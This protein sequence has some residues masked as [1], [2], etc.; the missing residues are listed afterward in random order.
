MFIEAF[1]RPRYD[2][3]KK[4]MFDVKIGCWPLITFGKEILKSKD[5][6]AG[7]DFINPITKADNNIIE[8]LLIDGII[9]HINHV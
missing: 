5:R 6:E 7:A 4:M 1:V 3:D 2:V 8:K 9:P